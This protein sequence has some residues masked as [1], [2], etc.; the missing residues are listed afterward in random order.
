MYNRRV[1]KE[2]TSKDLN[3][4]KILNDNEKNGEMFE[5]KNLSILST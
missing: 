1:R 3:N 5:L 4:E 2:M